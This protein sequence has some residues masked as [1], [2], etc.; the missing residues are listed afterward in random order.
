VYGLVYHGGLGST[1]LRAEHNRALY[2]PS[3]VSASG[4]LSNGFKIQGSDGY[5]ESVAIFFFFQY[6]TGVCFFR[7]IPNIMKINGNDHESKKGLYMYGPLSTHQATKTPFSPRN[8]GLP[9]QLE[10][11]KGAT[12]GSRGTG[13]RAGNLWRPLLNLD[14]KPNRIR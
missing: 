12:R 11:Q 8:N 3:G 6:Y 10:C 4:W 7:Y 14:R 13:L 9:D 5:A 1:V 2:R